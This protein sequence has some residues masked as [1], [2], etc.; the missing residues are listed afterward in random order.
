MPHEHF[1][2]TRVSLRHFSCPTGRHE[3]ADH[4]QRRLRGRD[5]Q[6]RSPLH[7]GAR[8]KRSELHVHGLRL[9]DRRVAAASR[10]GQNHRL[11]DLD[12]SVA[13]SGSTGFG[14]IAFTLP[15]TGWR[16][17]PP[18]PVAKVTRAQLPAP[19]RHGRDQRFSAAVLRGAGRHSTMAT[20][21]FTI[22]LEIIGPAAVAGGR[23]LR[24]ARCGA[25][26]GAGLGS[27]ASGLRLRYE[28]QRSLA[29]YVGVTWDRSFPEQ[30]I[31]REQRERPSGA[32]GSRSACGRGSEDASISPATGRALPVDQNVTLSATRTARGA[33]DEMFVLL[34]AFTK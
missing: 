29:P 15:R 11:R 25:P 12:A 8:Q 33:P 20:T 16:R 24:Q 5:F 9:S 17:P 23:G 32:R 2:I 10:S 22:D 13:D 21:R 14:R 3:A 26:F 27:I 7:G 1:R 6:V 18:P 31:C 19:T 34:S 28:F 30:L 4:R